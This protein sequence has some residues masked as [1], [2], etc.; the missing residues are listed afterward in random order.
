MTKL[1]EIARAMSDLVVDLETMPTWHQLARAA[2]DAMRE[3]SEEMVRAPEDGLARPYT[4]TNCWQDMIGA[5][6]NEK[7][8]GG[9]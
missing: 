8:G 3:P 9:E 1:E 7:P 2:V 5:I 6:L 4:V